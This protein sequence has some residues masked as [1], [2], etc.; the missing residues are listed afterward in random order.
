[1]RR[2]AYKK[3]SLMNYRLVACDMDGTLLNGKSVISP[4]NEAAVK[5]CIDKGIIFTI[6]TGRPVQAIERFKNQLGIAAPIIAYNGSRIVS[7]DCGEVIYE[8]CLNDDAAYRIIELGA[9]MGASM[10]VWAEDGLYMNKI[11]LTARHYVDLVFVKPVPFDPE[12]PCFKGKRITKILWND[13]PDKVSRFMERLP[14]KN[15]ESV[16]CFTS[17]PEYIEFVSKNVSKGIALERLC[18]SLG[19]EISESVAIGDGD[20]DVPMIKAAGLGVAMAN[21]AESVR[22][23]ADMVTL[24]NDE[25]GVAAVLDELFGDG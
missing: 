3:E 8:E 19:I 10:C 17:T 20:N 4:E 6:C 2:P 21:A 5:R 23:A 18:E 7:A 12:A 13:T 9:G 25:N 15:P 1:M 22:S 24:S 11:T 14:Q 16:S